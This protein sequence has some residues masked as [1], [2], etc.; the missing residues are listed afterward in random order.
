MLADA[1]MHVASRRPALEIRLGA[2][3]GSG[4]RRQIRRAPHQ[5]RQTLGDGVLYLARR[6]T[7]GRAFQVGGKHR[8]LAVPAFRQAAPLQRLPFRGQLRKSL[9]VRL[10]LLLPFLLLPRPPVHGLAHVAFNLGRDIKRLILG[11][12]VVALGGPHLVFAQ[13]LAVGF[14]G[15]LP[16]GRAVTDMRPH[17][18]KIRL[19]LL[20]V[21]LLN[22][23]TQRVQVIHIVHA[24]YVPAVCLVALAH[25]F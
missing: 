6:F 8:D 23:G 21:R 10:V 9:T 12:T 24:R 17:H 16:L 14:L 7:R 5:P 1:K 3:H 2:N 19:R 25:V 15:V 13:G 22:R 11:P 18:N 4:R 20:L